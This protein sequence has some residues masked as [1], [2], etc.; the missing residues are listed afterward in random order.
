MIP[1]SGV[2]S[3]GEYALDAFNIIAKEG[4]KYGLT[5]CVVT[6]RPGDIPEDLLSQVGTV[7][8]HRLVNESDRKRIER[9]SS[10][11]AKALNNDLPTLPPGEAFILGID[12][13]RALRLSIVS[14]RSAPRSRGP[15][16]QTFWRTRQ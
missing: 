3:A 9:M 12:F 13:P 7:I 4:R 6:Q 1:R 2:S 10:S 14:P 8:A 15:N 16:F 5:L 11:S